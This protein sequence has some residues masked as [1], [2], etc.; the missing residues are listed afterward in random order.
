MDQ[1]SEVLPVLPV[2]LL[3]FSA[4]PDPYIEA[5][6]REH[7][8]LARFSQG[9]VV[10]GYQATKDLLADDDHLQPGFG[11]VVDFYGV[12]GTMWARFMEEMV[13]SQSGPEHARLRA[14][15]ATAFTPRQA[16]Q[17]R[18]LMRRVI[19]ELLDDWAPSG[20]FDFA[21]FAAFFP[22]AV[23]SG[24]LG[25]SAE[26]IPKIRTALDNQLT[27]LTLD[28]AAKP[29]FMAG[30]E[31]L[32]SFADELVGER[33][34]R[35]A[36]DEESLLDALIA[37]KNAG[38]LD[39][40]ELRFMVLVLM[41]AGYDTSKNMLTLI[42]QMLLERPEMWRRCAEDQAYCAKVVEEALRHSAITTPYRAVA[43]DFDYEGVR[44]P[45]GAM[46]VFATSLAG[47]D[48]AAY[49][50]PLSFDPERPAG[51]RHV[52]FGRGGHICLGQFIARNQLEEG[53]HL[54]AQR[55]RNPRRAGAVVWRP[56]LGAWGLK[57]LPIAFEP[58][59]AP[60]PA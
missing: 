55:L 36:G 25:V 26:A 42:M 20:A 60:A 4:N 2:E 47:R 3:E 15:V 21:Q 22:V 35:G 39:A 32:W 58:A 31:V 19:T 27:S 30:W 28:P 46:V 40:T 48:P 54:I 43:K 50:E 29:L 24:L 53:L 34:A 7:P 8:W 18:P 5:A 38:Q 33:E 59:P 37:A 12:R 49:D 13:L 11:G 52:A 45:A 23:I 17:A 41:V 56:F 1:A 9:Y 10:H 57:T 14:S 44:F 16:N 51:P 6:R